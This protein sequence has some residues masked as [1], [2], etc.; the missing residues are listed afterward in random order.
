MKNKTK[1][2]SIRLNSE[3]YIRLYCYYCA[4]FSPQMISLLTND[5]IDNVYKKKS[6]LKNKLCNSNAADKDFFIG[7]IF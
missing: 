7:L 2:I 5:G 6:R 4:G 1:T 3:E